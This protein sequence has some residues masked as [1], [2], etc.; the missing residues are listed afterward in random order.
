[1][2]RIS[3]EIINSWIGKV[4]FMQ[5]TGFKMEIDADYM[6]QILQELKERRE[7]DSKPLDIKGQLRLMRDRCPR[8]WERVRSDTACPVFFQLAGGECLAKN[9][10]EC[11]DK[12]LE[13]DE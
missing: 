13:G 8:I 10:K 11:W 4:G 12:A 6:L 7:A 2:E 1:M 3:N 9:C 5:G